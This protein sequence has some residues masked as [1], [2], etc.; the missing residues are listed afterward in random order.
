MRRWRP[1]E[2]GQT[3]VRAGPLAVIGD[4]V[5]RSWRRRTSLR[6]LFAA[7]HVQL[8]GAVRSRVRA[9]LEADAVRVV[10]AMGGQVRGWAQLDREHEQHEQ[11]RR[12][13]LAQI[14]EPRPAVLHA[15][16]QQ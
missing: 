3:E 9:A 8:A 10:V 16:L 7:M 11:H 14:G 4:V 1:V 5:S 13:V 6:R 15:C 2:Q 12:P